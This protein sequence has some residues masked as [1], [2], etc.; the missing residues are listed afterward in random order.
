MSSIIYT[1]VSTDQQAADGT[2][3]SSQEAACKAFAKANGLGG[4]SVV[5]ESHTGSELWERPKL[6][7]VREKIR[8]RKIDSLICYSVD[9]LTRDIA[10]L[11]ILMDECE[12]HG[13]RALFVTEQLD[14]S[15]EGRLM[16]SVRGYVATVERIKIKERTVRGKR[17]RVEKGRLVNGSTPLYG[18][19]QDHVTSARTINPTESRIVRRIW[20]EAAKGFGTVRIARKLNAEGIQSPGAGKRNYKDGR[21]AQWSKSAV[22]RILREPAY[23][24]LSVAFRWKSEKVKGRR[25]R[26]VTERPRSEWVI[27]DD[28]LTPAIVTPE[29]FDGMQSLLSA[30]TC[31]DA[32]RNESHF[33]LLRGL[34][35][36][37]RCNRKREPDTS[38]N[39][40][41]CSSR[42]STTGRCGSPSTPIGWIDSLAWQALADG[43]VSSV[44]IE[45]LLL[46]HPAEDGDVDKRQERVRELE[47]A[48]A[49]LTARQARLLT[50]LADAEDELAGM[51]AGQVK[52]LESEKRSLKS[53]LDALARKSESTAHAHR[54]LTSLIASARDRIASGSLTTE[55]KRA[56]LESFGLHLTVDGKEDAAFTWGKANIS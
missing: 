50:N 3:L 30:R 11:M 56:Y 8:E 49:R 9:R 28:S 2:S 45:K 20:D 25:N 37:A 27:L 26:I 7:E 21:L 39:A 48:V 15:P 4:L 36:C 52:K 38:T 41:R 44:W 33:S 19:S 32:A 13:V 16:Q 18:Y 47:A 51:V 6:N 12:R 53:E 40:Y 17:T 14:D 29:E 55:R 54:S 1:R 42:S 24:G 31:G 46:R 10:H 34:I 23:A 35:F 43:L 22:L 5:R